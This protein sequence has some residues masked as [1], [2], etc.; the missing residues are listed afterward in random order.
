MFDRVCDPLAPIPLLNH[1][2]ADRA[3]AVAGM[4]SL[5]DLI[6]YR[7]GTLLVNENNELDALRS[8]LYELCHA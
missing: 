8:Q 7:N 1:L 5:N 3:R 6:L 2:S 4:G